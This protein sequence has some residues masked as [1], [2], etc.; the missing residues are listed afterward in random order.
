MAK[1]TKKE[2]EKLIQS[3][4]MAK[5]T[6]VGAPVQQFIR[7]GPVTGTLTDAE[8]IARHGSSAE[9]AK[10]RE[11]IE[12]RLAPGNE[13]IRVPGGIMLPAKTV[14]RRCDKC[15]RVSYQDPERFPVP[16]GNCIHCNWPNYVT[17]GHLV[18]MTAKEIDTFL[19]REFAKEAELA[20][21][22]AKARLIKVNEGR[23][24]S[25][26]DPFTPA[27]LAAQDE[28]DHQ[29]RLEQERAMAEINRKMRERREGN[30]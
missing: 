28:R 1:T 5:R 27:D 3:R 24:K 14:F 23:A 21:R 7:K 26:L 4:D 10:L 17:S 18:D 22:H 15:S 8:F 20:V 29:A 25:G 16:G 2:K 30:V 12:K 6:E 19:E 11:T 9:Q 13:W